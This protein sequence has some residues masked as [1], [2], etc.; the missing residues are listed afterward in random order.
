M[1]GKTAPH[2]CKEQRCSP[3]APKHRSFMRMYAVYATREQGAGSKKDLKDLKEVKEGSIYVGESS[4]SIYE[5]SKVIGGA[6]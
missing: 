5:R 3:N 4:R 6:K 2:A 1:G